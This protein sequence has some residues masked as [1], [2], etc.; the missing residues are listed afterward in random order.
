MVV[1][2]VGFLLMIGFSLI[3]GYF[4]LD[5]FSVCCIKVVF[6]VCFFGFIFMIYGIVCKLKD[7]IEVV[8][9]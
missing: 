2:I 5:I 3:E 8:N 9:F 4:E 7:K 6:V 1:I